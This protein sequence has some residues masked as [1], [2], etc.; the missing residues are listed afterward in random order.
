[1]LTI[2]YLGFF[3]LIFEEEKKRLGVKK[4]HTFQL[5]VKKTK[6]LG[7][8]FEEAK[9]YI[10]KD[11]KDKIRFWVDKPKPQRW[12]K[13]YVVMRM[14]WKNL[15]MEYYDFRTKTWSSLTPV[16]NWRS[17]ASLASHHS[18]VYLVGGE[19][20]DKE[21]PTGSRTVN[22]VT[23]YDCELQRWS[24]AP[25]MLLARRWAASTVMGNILYVVG[26]TSQA[27]YAS[28]LIEK[29]FHNLRASKSLDFM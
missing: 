22:R 18:N 29:A 17:C 13:I 27:S 11:T 5:Q 6:N 9:K 8:A 20:V 19:E 26:K 12:P 2:H 1:M 24:S 4:P 25:S 23:R 3:S 14:Y 10:G 21:S 15:P 7:I 28:Q 16:Q